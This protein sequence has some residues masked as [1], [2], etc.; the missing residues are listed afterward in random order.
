MPLI[1][2][3]HCIKVSLLESG[4]VVFTLLLNCSHSVDRLILEDDTI[5]SALVV[6]HPCEICGEFELES[7]APKHS[8]NEN[9][10]YVLIKSDRFTAS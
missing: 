10:T 7:S 9:V 3:K 5:L 1:I 8:V 2:S 6:N 4:T